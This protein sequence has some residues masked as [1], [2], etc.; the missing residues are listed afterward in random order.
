MSGTFSSVL[1]NMTFDLEQDALI[2][3]TKICHTFFYLD[4]SKIC[5]DSSVHL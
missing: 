4:L 3:F 1:Q 5:S 2:V